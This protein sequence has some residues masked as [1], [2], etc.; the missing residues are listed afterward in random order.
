VEVV[1]EY[2][3]SALLGILVWWVRR[4]FPYG[5]VEMSRMCQELTAPG[6]MA[7]LRAPGSHDRETA[8]G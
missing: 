2:H 5:P 1:A 3:A 7:S 6:V 4:D 8:T